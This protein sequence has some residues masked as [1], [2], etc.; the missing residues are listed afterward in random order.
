MS[1]VIKH[2]TPIVKQI[3][4]KAQLG[5]KSRTREVGGLTASDSE[6]HVEIKTAWW[7]AKQ[8]KKDR[9]QHS[10]AQHSG[11]MQYRARITL[12]AVG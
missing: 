7:V 8:K 10:I 6:R 11:G 5:A 3:I 4:R 9:K 2:F 12:G 1:Y